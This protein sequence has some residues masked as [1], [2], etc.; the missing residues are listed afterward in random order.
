MGGGGKRGNG[1]RLKSENINYEEEEKYKEKTGKQQ[2]GKGNRQGGEER[3][4][5][6]ESETS[7]KF[8]DSR[9]EREWL[10]TDEAAHFLC[11]SPNALRIMVHRGQIEAFKVGRRLR[12]RLRD[13]RALFSRRGA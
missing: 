3:Q 2:E 10:S 13:C 11:L 7:K 6:V 1:N 4:F 12:F 9:F 5:G 8:F